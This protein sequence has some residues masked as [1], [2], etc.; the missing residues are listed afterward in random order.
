VYWRGDVNSRTESGVIVQLR[1]INPVVPAL[2]TA[3]ILKIVPSRTLGV[4]EIDPVVDNR[5]PAGRF[6]AVYATIAR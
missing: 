6:E 1:S 3:V 5:S 2:V 4:P